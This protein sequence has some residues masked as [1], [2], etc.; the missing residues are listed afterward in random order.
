MHES[1][2][3]TFIIS[4][5]VII[6]A[7][8]FFMQKVTNTTEQ[9]YVLIKETTEAAMWDAFDVETYREDGETVRINREAFVEAFVRRFAQNAS[10][11]NT[12]VI[13][14]YDVNEY[15]PKVSL[16]VK[17][18]EGGVVANQ[19]FEF[20]ITNRLDA[21]LEVDGKEKIYNKLGDYL[22]GKQ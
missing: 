14:I 5:G 4:V 10:L 7:L 2:W 15:P 3:G 8:I 18:K 21:I 16:Q 9:N 6:I 20:D 12:Y 13:E 19:E 22:E 17:T 11:A 1:F